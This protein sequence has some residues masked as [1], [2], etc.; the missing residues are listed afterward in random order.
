M[1]K[2]AILSQIGVNY[3]NPTGGTQTAG[4][5]SVNGENNDYVG[6]FGKANINTTSNSTGGGGGYYG[7]AAS[8]SIGYA[9]FS[10]AGGSSFISGNILCNAISEGS[11]EEAIT[12]TGSF[13]HCSGKYFI[14]SNMIGGNESMPNPN[15]NENVIGN[16]GD[17]CVRITQVYL[18]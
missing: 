1:E 16:T 12:H 2:V 6:H 7:G 8:Q 11:T 18:E 9:M 13:L 4:G 15:S 17:G 5:L 10:G 3:T 14:F